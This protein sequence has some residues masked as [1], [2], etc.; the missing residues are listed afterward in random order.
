MQDVR[1]NRSQ[2][3]EQVK[4]NRDKH[5]DVF[6]KAQER[7]RVLVVEEL[8]RMLADARAGKKIRRAVQLI[9][10]EDH[11]H[12]Y[13]RVIRMLELSVDN[14]IKLSQA[15]FAQYVMD[16]WAWKHQW[17]NSTLNYVAAEA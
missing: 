3:L 10:P 12:D 16:D 17:A 5:R 9:E 14:E 1:V 8:D 13:D 11:T 7:Y 6:L 4:S 15:E 2:L